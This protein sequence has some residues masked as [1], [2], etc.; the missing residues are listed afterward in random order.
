MSTKPE[1][2][3]EKPKRKYTRKELPEIES[4]LDGVSIQ[5]IVL[6][7]RDSDAPPKTIE[8]GD[9]TPAYVQWFRENHSEEEF[10]ARYGHRKFGEA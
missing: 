5:E 1:T 6:P 4:Q 10:E 3:S 7:Q 8:S 9:K 2:S